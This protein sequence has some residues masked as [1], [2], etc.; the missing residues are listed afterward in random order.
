MGWL[1]PRGWTLG[2]LLLSIAAACGKSATEGSP[3]GACSVD[4]DCPEDQMCLLTAQAQAPVLI[5]P[6]AA[7]T[8]CSNDTDC[9]NNEVC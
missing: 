6:C 7:A 4:S 5:N 9:P 2:L 8:P 3:A 1:G